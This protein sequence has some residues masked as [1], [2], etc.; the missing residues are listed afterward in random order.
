ML[1]GIDGIHLKASSLKE[2]VKT[3]MSW[4]MFLYLLCALPSYFPHRISILYLL[5]NVSVK[6]CSG[7]GNYSMLRNVLF[8][9]FV[10]VGLLLRTK[11]VRGYKKG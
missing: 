9:T 4:V 7:L 8:L 11:D 6:S 10:F 1:V 2:L 5:I 3:S